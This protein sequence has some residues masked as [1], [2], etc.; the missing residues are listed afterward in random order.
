MLAEGVISAL[1]PVEVTVEGHMIR[2]HLV[3]KARLGSVNLKAFDEL[4]IFAG[5]KVRVKSQ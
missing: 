2:P 3:H 5:V 4:V 1:D